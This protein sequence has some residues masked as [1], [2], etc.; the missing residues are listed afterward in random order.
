MAHPGTAVYIGHRNREGSAV[1]V[2]RVHYELLLEKAKIVDHPPGEPFR[3]AG[4]ILPM[5]PADVQESRMA[6]RRKRQA[7]LA[8]AKLASLG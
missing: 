4:S 1:L 6:E 7:E 5:M 2:N 3:L 8:A